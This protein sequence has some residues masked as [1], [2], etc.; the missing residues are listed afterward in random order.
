MLSN[1]EAFSQTYRTGVHSDGIARLTRHFVA[2]LLGD[3]QAKTACYIQHLLHL[4]GGRK[5]TKGRREA[6]TAAAAGDDM[7]AIGLRGMGNGSV[8]DWDEDGSNIR[9]GPEV[10]HYE[11]ARTEG[12]AHLLFNAFWRASF[13]CVHQLLVRDHMHQIDLGVI[14]RLISAILKKYFECV[15]Q[16]LDEGKAGLAAQR[17]EERLRRALARS[18]GRNGQRYNVSYI[19]YVFDIHHMLYMLH[20]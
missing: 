20:M 16:F 11:R 5:S 18:T 3:Q 10:E 17:L 15:L 9:P 19:S 7:R 13:F 1:W 14:I 2:G 6:I 12:G 4:A 8:V